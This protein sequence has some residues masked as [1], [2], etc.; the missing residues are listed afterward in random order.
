[1]SGPERDDRVG[2]E[3]GATAPD[4]PGHLAP[5]TPEG[6]PHLPWK[7]TTQS[8]LVQRNSTAPGTRCWPFTPGPPRS[9]PRVNACFYFTRPASMTGGSWA[10]ISTT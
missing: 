6:K 7:R 2:S 8:G 4:G 9:H 10:G 1:M 3:A 5:Q